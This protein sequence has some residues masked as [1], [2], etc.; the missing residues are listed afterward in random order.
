MPISCMAAAAGDDA[1]GRPAQDHAPHQCRLA[2]FVER[3][4]ALGWE[5]VP[6]VFAAASPSAH[7]TEDAYERIAGVI[8]DGIRNARPLDAVY[9]ICTAPW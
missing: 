1:R 3:A 9:L 5:P 2:G 6:T 4:E 8:V 7:V